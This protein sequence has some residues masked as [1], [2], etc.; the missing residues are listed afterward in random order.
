M[1]SYS[2]KMLFKTK[3]HQYYIIWHG[4]HVFCTSI[5]VVLGET[6]FWGGG[7]MRVFFSPVVHNVFL[8]CFHLVPNGFSN[9]EGVPP[10]CAQ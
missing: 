10:R 2:M 5:V 7:G 9:S 8:S 4:P 3:Q 1:Q 6:R